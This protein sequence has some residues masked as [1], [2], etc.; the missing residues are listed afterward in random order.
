[1]KT[2]ELLQNTVM[3]DIADEQCYKLVNERKNWIIHMLTRGNII[4]PAIQ[5]TYNVT[6]LYVLKNAISMLPEYKYMKNKEVYIAD[7]NRCY[8]DVGELKLLYDRT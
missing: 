4:G 2:Y 5:D 1:M 8:C 3:P 7:N 6:I